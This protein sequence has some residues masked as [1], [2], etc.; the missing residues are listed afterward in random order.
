MF[1]NTRVRLGPTVTATA[2]V[3]VGLFSLLPLLYL[4]A[5]GVSWHDIRR[6]LRYP[7]VGAAIWQTVELTVVI[8]TV[9]VLVGVG[10]ALLVVRTTLPYPKLFTVLFALPLAVP[11]FV[12]AYAAYSTE[13]VYAP[14]LGLATSFWGASMVMALTLYP[15]VFLP[16][17]IALRAVDPAHEEVAASLRPWRA[18]IL[19]RV[20]LPALRPAIGGGVLIVALHVLAEFGAMDQLGRSTLTTKVMGEMLDYG[21]YR[22]ARS[23]SLLLMG[24]SIIVL[25]VTRWLTGRGHATDLARGTARPPR[26]WDL[27]PLRIPVAALALV[28]PGIAVGPTLFMTVRGLTTPERHIDV[29]WAQVGSALTTT[30]GYAVAAALVASVL[31]LPVSWWITRRPSTL[32]TL[33]ERCIWAA[34]ALPSAILGLALVYLATRAVPDLYKTPSVLVAS[35]VILFLPLAVA[36][37][38]VGLTVTRRAYDDVAA[39]LGARPLRAF[40]RIN[41]PLAIPGF[42]AGALLVGLDASKELNTTLMLIP[43]NAQTLSSQLWATT[44]G[45]SLDFTAASPYAAMLVLLGLPMVLMLTR[46]TLRHIETTPA[47]AVPRSIVRQQESDAGGPRAAHE[48]VPHG[49]AGTT[50]DL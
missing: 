41:L 16:S 17:V 25:L 21:D 44:N 32:A 33:T 12:S 39:S 35:Y 27:G 50:A 37:Q 23:L 42:L 43:Y 2:A 7:G 6:Q 48:H 1:S 28:V 49:G 31:A 38:R 30:L 36:N 34:H 19:W 4:L 20:V 47:G 15:Y 3:A 26:R 9:S 8:S 11:G 22:S 5:T 18:T 24:L 14:R 13:L 40:L 29:D 10:A 46:H 45:E